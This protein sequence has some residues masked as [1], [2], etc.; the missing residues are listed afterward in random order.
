MSKKYN[1]NIYNE[2]RINKRQK[3]KS[4]QLQTIYAIT[5]YEGI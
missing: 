4:S 2:F 3:I 5:W 1:I